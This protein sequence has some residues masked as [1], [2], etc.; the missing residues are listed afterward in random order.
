MRITAKLGFTGLLL[1]H[2]ALGGDFSPVRQ[3]E[4]SVF[5]EIGKER[6]VDPVLLYSV[7][8]IESSR[9][10]PGNTHLTAPSKFTLNA[11]GVA[12]YYPTRGEA[13]EKLDE[14]IKE[15][16]NVDIGLMQINYRWH[17]GKVKGYKDLLDSKTN[18]RIGADIL[19]HAL[20]SHKN[21]C[22]AIGHY[23]TWNNET[24]AYEY[25]CRVLSIYNRII[26]M[27]R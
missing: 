26:R 27:S 19:S 8:L 18:L 24:A 2:L 12:Y 11:G 17:K 21:R 14:L 13:L 5:G 16:N 20:G 10:V 6:G 9:P 3:I 15:S 7:A 25:G 23:H 22:I 4:N 1:A